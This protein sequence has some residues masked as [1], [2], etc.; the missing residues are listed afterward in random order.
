MSRRRFLDGQLGADV[1]SSGQSGGRPWS[2]R[3]R[4]LLAQLVEKDKEI[5]RAFVWQRGAVTQKFISRGLS[6]AYDSELRGLY[7]K[8]EA[9]RSSSWEQWYCGLSMADK[10]AFDDLCLALAG[11]VLIPLFPPDLPTCLRGPL[12]RL[13]LE[14]AALVRR[15]DA[16]RKERGESLANR[17]QRN[18]TVV[19]PILRGITDAE[20]E[21]KLRL[22]GRWFRELTP[23]QGVAFDSSGPAPIMARAGP[24][25]SSEVAGRR[26]HPPLT[27]ERLAYYHDIKE[28]WERAKG[29]GVRKIQF[30]QDNHITRE[31]LETALRTCRKEARE[32]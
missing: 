32:R 3:L 16:E 24:A 18:R 17:G 12:A 25:E 19:E 2:V 13:A 30:C 10:A 6:T 5:T 21:A 7:S 1:T 27:P 14:F 26:G 20:E 9:D 22:L 29:A 4:G 15:A 11:A 31:T 28:R 23:E 8:Q